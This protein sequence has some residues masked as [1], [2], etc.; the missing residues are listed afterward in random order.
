MRQGPRV[1]GQPSQLLGDRLVIHPLQQVQQLR[2]GAPC[3]DGG[4]DRV[5]IRARHLDAIRRDRSGQLA[6]ASHQRRPDLG[7]LGSIHSVQSVAGLKQ[8][9][10][11]LMTNRHDRSE[12]AD[13]ANTLQRMQ[14]AYLRRP[15]RFGGALARAVDAAI[16]IALVVAQR[17]THQA[18]ALVEE[19]EEFIASIHQ[20]LE[21]CKL[22][23]LIR[24]RLGQPDGL[25]HVRDHHQELFELGAAVDGAI[26]DL[27]VA[28]LVQPPGEGSMASWAGPAVDGSG[29]IGHKGVSF[30]S[31][32]AAEA[33]Q[34]AHGGEGKLFTLA[35]AVQ[36]GAK[37]FGRYTAGL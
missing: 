1:L 20:I 7:Q 21:D 5:Q 10:L 9:L 24:L 14:R 4:V 34:K 2:A 35:E 13:R 30:S 33:W 16:A 29:F 8:L 28:A 27:V 31:T 22:L 11:Q 23:A 15:H 6:H 37:T 36:R 32:E 25:G 19:L 26:A 12:A 17:G 3:L 18:L